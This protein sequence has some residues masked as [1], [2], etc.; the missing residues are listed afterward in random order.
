V[1]LHTFEE[2]CGADGGSS[3]NRCRAGGVVTIGECKDPFPVCQTVGGSSPVN[4]VP[5]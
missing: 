4:C 2:C 5:R 3:F 1:C